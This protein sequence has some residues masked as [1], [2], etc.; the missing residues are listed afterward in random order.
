MY[1]RYQARLGLRLFFFFFSGFGVA[2]HML[3][4]FFH[5]S[6]NLVHCVAVLIVNDQPCLV[7]SSILS[8]QPYKSLFMYRCS[9]YI[10]THTGGHA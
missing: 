6:S 3:Y 9:M 2:N 1:L 10:H 7:S 4:I 8:L 5:I